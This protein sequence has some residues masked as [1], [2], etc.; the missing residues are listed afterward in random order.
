MVSP[1]ITIGN[2]E[3][4]QEEDKWIYKAK[5]PK[6]LT[7]RGKAEYKE[8][9]QFALQVVIEQAESSVLINSMGQLFPSKFG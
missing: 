3:Y 5:E 1:P 8:V 2:F 6:P 9:P 4:T 7:A